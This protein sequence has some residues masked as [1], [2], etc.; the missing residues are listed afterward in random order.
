MLSTA[1]R[2]LADPPLS[3]SR[4]NPDLADPASLQQLITA[5][6][7]ST[8]PIHRAGI[9]F[10]PDGYLYVSRPAT[11]ESTPTAAQD[12]DTSL[13]GKILRLDVDA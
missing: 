7:P 9:G 11:P 12:V 3:V 5:H 10:G 4:G 8:T 13:T 6:D 2:Q 1:G